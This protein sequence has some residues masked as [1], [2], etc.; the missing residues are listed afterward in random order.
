MIDNPFSVRSFLAEIFFNDILLSKATIFIYLHNNIK[1]FVTNY[2]VAFGLNPITS[3]PI[4]PN[5]AIP[6]KMKIHY[7]YPTSTKGQVQDGWLIKDIIKEEWKFVTKGSQIADVAVCRC[8]DNFN[9]LCINDKDWKNLKLEVT[10]TVF[11]LGY[12]RGIGEQ[13]TPIWKQAT[14]ASELDLQT[15][16]K[17]FFY[18][19]TA[20][21]EGMSGAPVIYYNRGNF[22]SPRVQLNGGI[23][24]K[25]MGVYSGRILGEDALAAQ[26]GI[27]WNKE[28]IEEIITTHFI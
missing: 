1:Y 11:V 16:D 13:G 7:W 3:K 4:D 5:C 15:P 6:N 12:P 23:S 28:L 19:D 17:P 8:D 9:G 27:V 10:D 26:L 18:I 24:S 21:R 14:I 2:H 22:I 25:F 20:T